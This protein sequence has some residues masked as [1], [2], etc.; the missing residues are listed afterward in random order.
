M[1]RRNATVAIVGAGDFNPFFP[2]DTLTLM[3]GAV[4]A[5]R[6]G[7]FAKYVTC[8]FDHMW[9]ESKK[10]D[11]VEVIRAALTGEGLDAAAI[12]ALAQDAAVKQELLANTQRSVQRGAFGSPTFFVDE[13]MYFGKD[14]L[15]DVE[16][17]IRAA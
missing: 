15:A 2:V 7:V 3:R 14:R 13:E 6:L 17:A 9:A 8:V 1:T 4:A 16:E 10:M 12:L 5:Q 11:E